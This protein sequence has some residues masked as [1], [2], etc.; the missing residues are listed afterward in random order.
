M[1]WTHALFA[2]VAFVPNGAHDAGLCCVWPSFKHWWYASICACVQS[3]DAGLAGCH[4]GWKPVS[5]A[6]AHALPPSSDALPSSPPTVP[7][8]GRGLP[9][10]TGAPESV[11]VF[12]LPSLFDEQ[13]TAIAPP[14]TA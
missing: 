7:V 13:P 1:H 3:V 11:G 12:P 8:S 5:S 4:F 9:E 2:A 6:G 14:R 10:S